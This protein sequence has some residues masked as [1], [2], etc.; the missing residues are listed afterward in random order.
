M[1]PHRFIFKFDSDP[2]YNE[3]KCT[4][5]CVCVWE[6]VYLSYI[7]LDHNSVEGGSLFS[8]DTWFYSFHFGDFSGVCFIESVML[9]LFSFHTIKLKISGYRLKADL[10]ISFLLWE[11]EIIKSTCSVVHP[12]SFSPIHTWSSLIKSVF[13]KSIHRTST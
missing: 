4:R 10:L 8:L 7:L 12:P 3:C 2:F 11:M 1:T 9:N 6:R 13:C 5:A